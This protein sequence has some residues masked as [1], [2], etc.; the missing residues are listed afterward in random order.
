MK[1]AIITDQFP[2]SFG[3]MASH[4]YYIAR[5]FGEKN[6]QVMVIAPKRPTQGFSGESFQVANLLTLKFPNIDLYLLLRFLKEFAPD[7]VHICNAGLCYKK[8]T[9][10]YKILTRVVGNDFL[11]PWCGFNLKLRSIYYRVPN[12]RFRLKI[13]E[14]EAKLRKKKV[15]DGLKNS[16]IVVANSEWTR[17]QLLDLNIPVDMIAVIPGGVDTNI[18][19]PVE[20]K[21]KVRQ[22]LGLPINKMILL[23]AAGLS[24]KKGIDTVIKSLQI[25]KEK[26]PAIYFIVVGTGSA[27]SYLKELTKDLN[28]QDYVFFAGKIE[29]KNI[30]NYF[31]AADIYV[32]PSRTEKLETGFVEVAETMGRTFIEAGACKLPVITTN[33][34]GIPSMV[35]DNENGILLDD[36]EDV[37]LLSDFIVKIA[38]DEQ[39]RF[40]MGKKGLEM[41]KS[42]FSWGKIGSAYE[43]LLEEILRKEM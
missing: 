7:V 31:Q 17:D 30:R 43:N 12:K 4:A 16:N 23:A 26:V 10:K 11:R 13:G 2:P 9:D 38:R 25:V 40:K 35:K 27:S 5:Y 21:I 36:P 29:Q 3:G 6:H 32:Q 33:A 15:I 24:R 18:F 28:L 8:L 22:A 20:N 14:F 39:L 19:K 42:L 1:I 37:A 34:G 41:A